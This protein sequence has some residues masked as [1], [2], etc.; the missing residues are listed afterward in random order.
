M[1][2]SHVRVEKDVTAQVHDGKGEMLMRTKL[3]LSGV[4]Q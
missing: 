4:I 2:R 3:L 1:G